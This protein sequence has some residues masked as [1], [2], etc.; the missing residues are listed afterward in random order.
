[1]QNKNLFS[2]EVRSST[3]WV[4]F[5][6]VVTLGGGFLV[7][8]ATANYLG[9]EEYGILVFA[10]SVFSLIAITGHL[11]LGNLVV[12]E[13]VKEGPRYASGTLGTI[14]VI[15]FIGLLLGSSLLTYL[16]F[17]YE[18]NQPALKSIFP[19][20]A[21][22]LVLKIADVFDFWFQSVIRADVVAKCHI[23]SFCIAACTSLYG[24]K[25]A[26]PVEWFALYTLV[27]GVGIFST[28]FFAY[29]FS[30]KSPRLCYWHF[31]YER[32]RTLAKPAFY[33]ALGTLF[34]LM[35]LKVDQIMLHSLV[36][37]KE[38]G[39]YSVA[40]QISE[41]WIFIPTALVASIFPGL[42]ILKQSD[43]IKFNNDFKDIISCLFVMALIVVAMIFMFG[44]TIILFFYG[45][46]Y[47]D[48]ILI[49]KIHAF[50]SIFLFMRLAFS[51]WI[52]IENALVFS[53]IT[54]FLGAIINIF[55]NYLVI[56]KYGGI[57][58]AV[59]TVFS[60]SISSYWALLASKKTFPIFMN[61]T[62]AILSPI[63]SFKTF[64]RT[65]KTFLN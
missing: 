6:Q 28:L 59:V 3:L 12:H 42:I 50:G 55:L 32:L 39:I 51:R 22:A 44:K 62:S 54:H 20:L 53:L 36:G 35:S 38:V 11:G 33:S 57:G 52:M 19:I 49:L 9:P 7:T 4:T 18:T 60:Y 64:L 8:S 23:F 16:A 46:E 27:T 48:S 43:P 30:S 37:S 17:Y 13:L 56:P 15:K 40:A 25:N 10:L 65:V 31:E 45:D 5:R 58:A 24:I 1:M 21:L 14:T 26:K 47:L 2:K 34:S 29:I 61:M 41:V 63:P